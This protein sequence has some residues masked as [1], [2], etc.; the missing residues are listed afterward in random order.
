MGFKGGYRSYT[1]GIRCVGHFGR[2]NCLFR[3]RERER[4]GEGLHSAVNVDFFMELRE[5]KNLE[6]NCH[7]SW[8]TNNSL[9]P[10]APHL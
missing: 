6:V 5:K 10:T 1:S 4:G 8:F 2:E 3:E 7:V 9:S